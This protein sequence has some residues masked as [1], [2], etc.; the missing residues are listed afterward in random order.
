MVPMSI[1]ATPNY[2]RD[3]ETVCLASPIHWIS[4]GS[5]PDPAPTLTLQ[6][7]GNPMENF[8]FF[9]QASSP[10]GDAIA[11]ILAKSEKSFIVLSP[12]AKTNSL[13]YEV[14]IKE[15]ET[16]EDVENYL[17]T[18]EIFRI[19]P[20]VYNDTLYNV[21]GFDGSEIYRAV[22]SEESNANNTN[23]D[24]AQP[25]AEANT[26]TEV[27]GNIDQAGQAAPAEPQLDD[28]SIVSNHAPDPIPSTD[29]SQGDDKVVEPT[30]EEKA[31]TAA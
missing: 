6:S 26:Q 15:F 7:K 8:P 14:D 1:K 12:V 28:G 31:A 25:Q 19:T 22:E 18:S 30:P 17:G 13:G 10:D 27:E 29:E 5:I 24:A 20:R 3:E 4:S 2:S 23:D 9:A 16:G 11:L 21:W